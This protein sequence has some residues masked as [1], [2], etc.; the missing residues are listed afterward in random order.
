[1]K[2][3][4]PAQPSLIQ[5]KHQAKDLLKEF[6]AGGQEAAAR[7]REHHPHPAEPGAATLSDAHLVMA[8][9]YGFASWPRFKQHVDLVADV[10]SRVL[11]LQSEFASG[12][13]QTK[14]RLL[15]TAH[16]RERFQ[17]Y[18]PDAALLSDADARLLFAN[19]KGYAYWNK[20]DSFLHLDPAVQT[21]TA[22]VRTGDL[23]TLR[24][25]LRAEPAAANPRW[26]PSFPVPK[27]VPNDSIPLFCVSEGVWRGTNQGGNEYELTRE[28]IAAGA[29]VEIEDGLPLTSAVSF[30]AIGVVKALLD[31]GANADGVDRD[32]VPLAYAMHFGF[33]EGA[34]LLAARGARLDLRFAAGLGRLDLVKGWFGPDG[35]LKPGAGSLADPYGLER[36]QKGE[37][38]FRC[39]RTRPNILS[40]ALYFA[41][42]HNKLDV[43]DFLLSKGADVN[44]MVPGL[45]VRATVLHRLASMGA[46]GAAIRFLLARGADPEIRDAQH[47]AT[48]ADWA[49][50]HKQDDVV[51]LLRS[52]RP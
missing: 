36:K 40:Q 34:D 10:E 14:L 11:R 48:P 44:A 13:R 20:Y 6:R 37:S 47:H 17:N 21:A 43:A 22:A 26:V 52:R 3:S 15:A 23:A 38:P 29:D 1:M 49:R 42:I 24:E 30:N 50:Y 12:D 33:T 25:I 2:K 16:A 31:C 45:D 9:E 41:C 7:F 8:R 51:D 32:G 46:H 27:P 4:L 28:L 5:L 18:D 35:S 39:Q 19:Q